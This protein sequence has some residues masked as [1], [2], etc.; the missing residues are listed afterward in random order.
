MAAGQR[1][2]LVSAIDAVPV[3]VVVNRLVTVPT[4]TPAAVA[5]A[6]SRRAEPSLDRNGTLSESEEN[7]RAVGYRPF[8]PRHSSQADRQR[9]GES[10]VGVRRVS[11]RPTIWLMSKPSMSARNSGLDRYASSRSRTSSVSL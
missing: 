10:T 2:P 9:K 6:R 4:S 3:V 5:G 7:R 11:S 8:W 1:A